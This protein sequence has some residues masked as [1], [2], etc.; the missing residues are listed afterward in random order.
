MKVLVIE[1]DREIIETILLTFQMRWPETKL[2]STHLGEQGVDIA[3]Q[4]NPDIV[5]LDLGLVDISGYTVLQQIRDFSDVPILILTVRS[6]EADIVKGLEW[7]ADD[8]VVKPF[9]QLELLSR[10]RA[11]VRRKPQRSEERA[12]TCGQ[13]HFFPSRHQLFL[14]SKE[15]KLTPTESRVLYHLM[16]NVGHI[17]QYQTLC[18]LVWNLDHQYAINNLKVYIGRLR[19]VIES[20]P[21]NP[22]IILTRNNVGYSL[23]IPN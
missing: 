7:G 10:V 16:K 11:I 12:L 20:D 4:E 8:Y 5:I 13:L 14:G 3:R 19:K 21:K 23:T 17:V 6:N 2:L 15:I 9:R 22:E 1:D 18:N